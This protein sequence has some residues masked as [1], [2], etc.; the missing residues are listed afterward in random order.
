[1]PNCDEFDDNSASKSPLHFSRT[2]GHRGSA[3]ELIVVNAAHY[4]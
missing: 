4:L 2:D 1:M 3:A